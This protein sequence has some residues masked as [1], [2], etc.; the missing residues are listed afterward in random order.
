MQVDLASGWP[1]SG[2]AGQAGR[3]EDEGRIIPVQTTNI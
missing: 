3:A 1:A 2:G